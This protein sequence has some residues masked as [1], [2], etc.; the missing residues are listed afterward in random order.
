MLLLILVI[1]GLR[2]LIIGASANRVRRRCLDRATGCAGFAAFRLDG[3]LASSDE[4]LHHASRSTKITARRKPPNICEWSGMEMIR[5][6]PM[7]W[8][9]KRGF[10]R[11]CCGGDDSK[12][13]AL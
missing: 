13:G 5:A 6:R 7:T 10:R 1:R 12:E 11:S 3:A 4:D 8:V 2:R 9:S